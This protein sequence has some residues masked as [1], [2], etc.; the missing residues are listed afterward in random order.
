[1]CLGSGI[2]SAT[3]FQLGHGTWNHLFLLASIL[4][5]FYLYERLWELVFSTTVGLLLFAGIEALHF[6][7][8]ES[9]LVGKVPEFFFQSALYIDIYNILLLTISLAYYNRGV[10]LKIEK[11]LDREKEISESLLLNILPGDIAARLKVRPEAVADQVTE[12]SVLFADLVGFTK[13]SQNMPAAQLVAM[14]N[15]VFVHFDR[16]AKKLGLEKIKTIGDAYM[17]AAGIPSPRPDHARACV[18]MAL[19]MLR[20]MEAMREKFPELSVRIGIHCGPLVAGVIGESKY[21]YDL[22]GDTV[23]TA[24][25]MES[26]GLP[27]RIHLSDEVQ[28]RL[29]SAF[30]LED[31]GAIEIKGKGMMRTW[32]IKNPSRSV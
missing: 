27:G 11:A 19:G 28:K 20:H 30:E 10:L 4:I 24:S 5:G 3:A 31:R 18:D 32:L 17:V 22:W 6:L 9:P 12:A 2:I 21:A 13:I 15:E 14:L 8:I 25:R 26:H 16:L 7:G 29:E 1:L 23:N